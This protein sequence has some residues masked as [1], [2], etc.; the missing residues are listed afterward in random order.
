MPSVGSGLG[1]SGASGEVIDFWLAIEIFTVTQQVSAERV[2]DMTGMSRSK[3]D[4]LGYANGEAGE[5]VLMS[6]GADVRR[7]TSPWI[8]RRSLPL[9]WRCF[10]R[11]LEVRAQGC[12]LQSA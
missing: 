10:A 4:A 9:V 1:S 3:K 5:G 11:R 8:Q 2:H 6:L 7:R 12:E